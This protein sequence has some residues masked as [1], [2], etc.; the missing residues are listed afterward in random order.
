MS[1]ESQKYCGITPYY[2]SDTSLY[3]R[4]GM[5]L[6]VS[7]AIWQTFISKVLDEILNRKHFLA[8]MDDC[9]IHSKRKDPLSHLMALIK[10]LIRQGLNISPRKCQL[11]QQ[12]FTYMCQILLLKDNTTCI[13]PMRSKTDAIQR[14]ELP[15]TPKECTRFCEFIN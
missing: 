2:G 3:Q 15:K 4:P 5:S 11:F 8:I 7:P 6:N 10:V 9:M 1:A 13:T 12:K 14:L